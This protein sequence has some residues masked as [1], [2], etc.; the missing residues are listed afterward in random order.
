MMNAAPVDTS[1]PTGRSGIS[2]P[3]LFRLLLW[4][5]W[6]SLCANLRA[7]RSKSRLML[8]V[9]GS[10]I[11]TY[12][13]AGYW[14]FYAGLNYLHN[15]PIVGTLIA[16][17]IL[18]LTFAFFFLMLVFSNGIIGYASL[19]KNRETSWLMTLPV[20]HRS[21]YRWKFAE[22]LVVSS[23]ALAF[24]SAPMMAAY[25][26]VH[27]VQPLF[28]IEVLAAY[29]P[30]I[31]LPALAGSW[32][33]LLFVRILSQAW[34]KKA[35]LF[36]SVASVAAIAFAVK[37]VGDTEAVHAQDVLSFD[38][39]LRHTRASL[40]PLLPSAWLARSVLSWSEGLSRQ[41][42]FFFL[43]L[44]S[45]A[46]M[47]LL[48]G[49]EVVGRFFYGSWTIAASSRAERF[50]RKA[51]AKRRK[52]GRISFGE[53]LLNRAPVFSRPVKA[54]SLKDVRVFWRDPAQW[55][56]FMIFFGL[57][58]IYVLNLRNVSFDLQNEFWEMLI[59]DLN[60][61]AS[62]LTLSTLT[63]RFVFPQFS[64]EGRRLWI[65]GLAPLGLRKVL[66]QKFWMSCAS[67]A[68]VT[69]S[70]MVASS[71]MLHMPWPRVLFFASA[72]AVMSATLC[73]LA[74]GLGAL[75][76]NLKE[77]NPSKIVSGF[78]GTL[79]LVVSFIY[80]AC[81]VA[82]VSLPG[83]RRVTS[84]QFI[85][86]DAVAVALAGILSAVVLLFPMILAIKRVKN[87]E[88]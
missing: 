73:G 17:R 16:Q 9:L 82:L 45:N 55:T 86:S 32:G 50:Q 23:W 78:G 12:L 3:K 39:L 29:V 76:P 14:L 60:L 35:L 47:G 22:S 53:W 27:H 66:L 43:V 25:G 30:F 6:R 33:I 4:T 83:L 63:T 46:L 65:I 87:L 54:L 44:L 26:R 56:Q 36:V 13:A 61:A 34:V 51:E 7:I 20:S 10:F 75:F 1:G 24:L 42:A 40:N 11:L 80:I 18:F 37:P 28:Y 69:V 77:D 2:A 38:A 62:S 49:F 74:V 81:F 48:V 15:F 67:A 84:V 8:F 71:L 52:L 64:L 58:C 57:L 88:F 70:L 79:C 72:I 59:S 21:V 85:I 31:V 19:F 68:A 41:G 5:R